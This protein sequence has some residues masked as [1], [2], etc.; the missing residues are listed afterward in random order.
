M[1]V[2]NIIKTGLDHWLR[3]HYKRAIITC[4]IIIAFTMIMETFFYINRNWRHLTEQPLELHA[5]FLPMAVAVSFHI[6][7][8]QTVVYYTQRW[9][10][11]F[12]EYFHRKKFANFIIRRL[13][14]QLQL[15]SQK[16]PK[17]KTGIDLMDPAT[18]K[19][20]ERVQKEAYH[21]VQLFRRDANVI[22]DREESRYIVTEE[23]EEQFRE[24]GIGHRLVTDKLLRQLLSPYGEGPRSRAS[25]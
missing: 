6:G 14:Y 24:A 11:L 20:F 9:I 23:E 13:L 16:L 8:Q 19:I 1:R 21:A 22:L 2:L 15:A 25:R 12:V 7:S 10:K 17:N 3:R 5:V 18:Q 4:M